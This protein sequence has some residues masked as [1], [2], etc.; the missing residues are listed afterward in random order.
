MKQ[1]YS[2]LIKRVAKWQ[3]HEAE[4]IDNNLKET[5]RKYTGE[6]WSLR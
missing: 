3:S 5:I 1:S 4:E 6:K 2:L